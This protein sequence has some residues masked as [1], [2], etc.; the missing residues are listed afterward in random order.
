MAFVERGVIAVEC[1]L[2][3]A[4]AGLGELGFSRFQPHRAVNA[5]IDRLV[6]RYPRRSHGGIGWVRTTSHQAVMPQNLYLR[7]HVIGALDRIQRVPQRVASSRRPRWN[8]R[9]RPRIA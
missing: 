1:D 8:H 2:F 7:V 4:G 3:N 5:G 9:G 6:C